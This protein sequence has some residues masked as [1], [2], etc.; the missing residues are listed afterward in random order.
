MG[1]VY[2]DSG[3]V[4]TVIDKLKTKLLANPEFKESFL[5]EGITCKISITDPD[6][7]MYFDPAH[8]EILHTGDDSYA[9]VTFQMNSDTMHSFMLGKLNVITELTNGRIKVSCAEGVYVVKIVDVMPA[10]LT[11]LDIYPTI[12]D[13]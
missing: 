1:N 11:I 12:I 9:D 5:K 7:T 6:F 8:E 2:Q 10:L 4:L 13:K 3:Q